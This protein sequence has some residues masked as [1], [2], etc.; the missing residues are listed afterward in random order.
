MPHILHLLDDDDPRELRLA[1]QPLIDRL[2]SARWVQF[3]A[4][5]SGRTPA[6]DVAGAHLLSRIPP[7]FGTHILSL[8]LL[9]RCIREHRIDLIH[10]WSLKAAGTAALAAGGSVPIA[11][12]RWDPMIDPTEV[13]RLA[14]LNAHD[15]VGV[16]C[17]SA[18]VRRRLIG[19]GTEA[20][21]CAV[22]R[23]GVDFSLLNKAKHDQTLKRELG[24]QPH[25]RVILLSAPPSRRGGHLDGVWVVETAT[26]LMPELLL[27]LPGVSR[28]QQK[29]RRYLEAVPNE[30]VVRMTGDDYSFERL[31]GIADLLLV[32]AADDMSTTPVAWAMAAAV[33]ILACA[34]YCVTE[35]IADRQ[36]GHLVKPG[37]KMAMMGKLLDVVR[38]RGEHTRLYDL[39]RA[40]AFESFSLR[41]YLEQVQQAWQNLLA[42]RPPATDLVDSALDV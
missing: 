41:R 24:I 32:P 35:F 23:P 8:P 37:Q 7:R 10:A 19:H 16:L 1:L 34:T 9:Q 20:S 12:T 6:L 31:L 40:Q 18:M 36:N 28:E 4:I 2:P 14:A 25:Q 39:A 26:R 15:R 38:N 27:L 33:P 5:L 13:A 17:H 3:V 21:R 42:D 22:V 11:V 30:A 29:I